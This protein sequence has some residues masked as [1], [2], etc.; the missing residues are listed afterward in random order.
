MTTQTLKGQI[1]IKSMNSLDSLP[2]QDRD[3]SIAFPSRGIVPSIKTS[4]TLSG[5]SLLRNERTSTETL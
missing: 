1:V 2:G 4:D 3:D 5:L